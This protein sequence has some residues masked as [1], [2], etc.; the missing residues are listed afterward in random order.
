MWPEV[1]LT[2]LYMIKLTRGMLSVIWT[3]GM[4][5]PRGD[6]HN[7][8]LENATDYP[9]LELYLTTYRMIVIL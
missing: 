1:L 7:L 8:I 3:V 6:E 2:G 9:D 4:P 5:R